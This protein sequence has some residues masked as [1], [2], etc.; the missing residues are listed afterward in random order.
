MTQTS[1]DLIHTPFGF[2]STAAEVI[3]GIDLSG[4]RAIVTG[5]SSGIGVET[6]RALASAGAEVTLAVRDTQAGERTASDI[7]A[8]TGRTVHV[9][10][11]RSRRPSIGRRVRRELDRAASPLDQQRRGDGAARADAD[12]GR[13]GDAVR[14][15]PPRPLRARGWASRLAYRRRRRADR[16]AQLPRSPALTCRLRGH[17]LQLPPVRPVA[18]LRPVEDRQRPVR[19]RG[20]A[21]L[22]RRRHH[23]QRGAP[24][25]DRGDEPLSAH[26]PRK[27]SAACGLRARSA[28][29]R[30]GKAQRPACS[31]RHRRNSRG[32]G[33]ATSRTATKRR[34]SRH[35]P[36][37]QTGPG[38]Y[39]PLEEQGV[40][41]YALDPDNAQAALGAVARG[42]RR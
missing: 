15:Q 6:A 29:R 37:D 12:P 38:S 7:S 34:S 39:R 1:P 11:A 42:A 33:A 36:A 23:G 27:S 14:D 13:L 24:G 19:G 21:A 9:A 30:S 4:K 26:E 22:G 18:R 41:D 2:D 5:A 40:A 8:S 31:S 17:Q 3:E 20:D 28:S 10:A 16:V 25:R 35:D 32:L